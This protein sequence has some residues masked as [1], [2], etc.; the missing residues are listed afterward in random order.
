MS[1][2]G[3]KKVIVSTSKL[4]L[5]NS[6][7]SYLIR[8]RIVSEDKNRMSH[9]SPNYSID[10]LANSLV[11]G[12]LNIVGNTVICAWEDVV[13]RPGYDIFV[14]LNGANPTYHGTSPT[15]TY[16]FLKPSGS[17]VRIVVQVEGIKKE[18]SPALKIYDSN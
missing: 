11:D 17:T 16:S 7:N 5:V 4:G 2:P 18:L 6:N 13:L 14:G 9:W 1:D 15:H 12:D 8:Y 3:I 10:A